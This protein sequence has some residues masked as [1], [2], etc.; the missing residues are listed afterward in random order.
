MTT[1]SKVAIASVLRHRL[2]VR[3]SLAAWCEHNGFTPAAHHKLLI[4]KLEK[5]TLPPSPLED[6]AGLALT[7]APPPTTHQFSKTLQ[8]G[9][10]HDDASIPKSRPDTNP[11]LKLDRLA[12]FMPPGAA[13]STYA[14][15]L[16]PPWYLA[17]NP[18]HSIIAASHTADL[19]AKWG[20]RVR[21][22]IKENGHLL[23]YGLA[24]DSQ[25]AD[26]WETDSGAEY[27]AFGVGGS[28]TGRRAD[29][30]VR[31]PRRSARRLGIGTSPIF[32][33]G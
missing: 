18:G 25:A 30:I 33:R 11:G 21:N 12:V 13:K 14:S 4:G 3:T 29:L 1:P 19:A 22:I 26:R 31:S 17:H 5:L 28:V 32:T 7:G 24:E 23:G 15:I 20:R 16:F 6:G 9:I 2:N 8:L 10:A 27:G